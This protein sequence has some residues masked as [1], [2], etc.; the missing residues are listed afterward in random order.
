M[1][2]TSMWE[3]RGYAVKN[4]QEIEICT[5]E[6]LFLGDYEESARRL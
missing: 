1:A 4:Q 6:Y 3:I 5:P 2:T